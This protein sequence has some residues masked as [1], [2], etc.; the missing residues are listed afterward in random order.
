MIAALVFAALLQEPSSLTLAEVMDRALAT[1]PGVAAARALRERAAAETGEAR[2]ARLPRVS[3][4]AAVNRF[5][6]P[7]VVAPLH[8]FDIRNPPLFD[9]T[10]V[11][12]G[13]GA[14]WVAFDFGSRAGHVRVQRL[15][16]D[17]ADLGV[18]SAEQDLMARAVRAYLAVLTTRELLTAQD[19]RLA[20]LRAE[21]AR[22]RLL[23]AQGKAARVAGLRINAEEQRGTADRIAVASRLR[24]AEHELAQIAGLPR[25]AVE[26]MALRAVRLADTALA[27]DST[28]SARERLVTQ[29]ARTSAR[30]LELEQRVQAAGAGVAALRRTAFPELRLS[31]AYVDRGRWWGN[32]SAEWQVGLGIS[33]SVYGGGRESSIRKAE[34][35]ERGAVAQLRLARMGVETSV[36][37]ALGAMR[38]ARARVAALSGAVDQSAEVARIERLALDVGSGTQSDFLEA[39]ANL[40]GAR[41]GLIDARH[42]EV[43]ARVELARLLGE[44]TRAWITR[45][46][47]QSP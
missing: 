41:A 13:I 21:A 42:A 28:P 11:Q 2:S 18:R 40:L 31:S 17:A 23:L 30:L 27:A 29:A 15:L 25:P 7:M 4:D 35:D 26:G 44:L 38:E 24:T 19:Q 12:S 5:E 46:L 1:H 20:A 6:E 3:L 9:R 16:E 45:T 36:D 34:A 10:L 14:S 8:G 33:Y 47:E 39:E 32:Y 22:V 43:M 37:Q